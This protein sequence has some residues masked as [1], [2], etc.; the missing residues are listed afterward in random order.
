MV[1]AIF[2]VH[3]SY[4]VEYIPECISLAL[5][6]LLILPLPSPLRRLPPFRSP[7]IVVSFM[8]RAV[9]ATYIRLVKNHKVSVQLSAAAV[10][11]TAGDVNA[12]YLEWSGLWHRL[13]KGVTDESDT[14]K[15]SGYFTNDWSRTM[16]MNIWSVFV[17]TP[18]YMVSYGW[19]DRAFPA[20]TALNIFRKCA[21]AIAVSIPINALFFA[22]GQFYPE[23]I[24]GWKVNVGQCIIRSVEKVNAELLN[25]LKVSVSMWVPLNAFNFAFVPSTHRVL[26]TSV[27][28]VVWATYLSIC[29]KR[30]VPEGIPESE[31]AKIVR[32]TT[33]QQQRG[34]TTPFVE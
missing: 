8:L 30:K 10:I 27:F 32:R 2:I 28:S 15:S 6:F 16:E 33:Q 18:I 13:N 24:S 11:F 31:V 1:F 20:V 12:Q 19:M 7:P 23:I 22:Y 17:Y 9:N 21:G 34:K 25:T 4:R 29:Q 14:P 5:L 26:Y 3:K